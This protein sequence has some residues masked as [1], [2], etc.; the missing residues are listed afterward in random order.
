MAEKNEYRLEYT[1]LA[2]E[3]LDEILGYIAIELQVPDTAVLQIERIEAAIA[4]LPAFPHKAPIA[5]DVM[6]AR[7]G[8]RMLTVD[9]FAVFYLVDDKRLVVSIRRIL[10]GKRNYQWML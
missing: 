2:Y 4:A 8:V 9:N 6:L 1:P 10:Y 7:K 5:R 3:D